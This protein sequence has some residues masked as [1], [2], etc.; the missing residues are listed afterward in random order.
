MNEA[1]THA[2]VEEAAQCAGAAE[3]MVELET[4]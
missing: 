1:I 3:V 2:L 4:T